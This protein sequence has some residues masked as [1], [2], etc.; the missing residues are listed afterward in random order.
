MSCAMLS[1]PICSK[2]GP[3]SVSS[4]A[5]HIEMKAATYIQMECGASKIKM[6][7]MA[8]GPPR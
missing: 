5:Q 1:P 7:R 4:K 2:A 6:V 8:T 3:I